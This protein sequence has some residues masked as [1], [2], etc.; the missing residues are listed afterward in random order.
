MSPSPLPPFPLPHL[1]LFRPQ[2]LKPPTT[3][4]SSSS[5]IDSS[6]ELPNR[7]IVSEGPLEMWRVFMEDPVVLDNDPGGGG[8]ALARAH[9]QRNLDRSN[10]IFRPLS[11]YV[12]RVMHSQNAKL[13]MAKDTARLMDIHFGAAAALLGVASGSVTV[14][15]SNAFN[16]RLDELGK[17][18]LR[19]VFRGTAAGSPPSEPVYPTKASHH[20]EN[21]LTQARV[22]FG[23]NVFAVSLEK[24][25]TQNDKARATIYDTVIMTAVMVPASDS[26]SSS[27]SSSSAP[28]LPGFSWPVPAYVKPDVKA[29]HAW[30][31][32]VVDMLYGGKTR[33][34]SATSEGTDAYA[35]YCKLVSAPGFT[36][37]EENA[38]P[39]RG[40]IIYGGHG[41]TPA[42]GEIPFFT[43][44]DWQQVK[45]RLV[46]AGKVVT[47][48]NDTPSGW[49]NCVERISTSTKGWSTYK[50][51]NDKKVYETGC[52]AFYTYKV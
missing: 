4:S 40:C 20:L 52:L 21:I 1:N 9:A 3:S 2:V 43:T 41:M 6:F 34:N 11:S 33:S 37:S 19:L 28:L 31:V 8:A 45:M 42:G 5:S 22:S 18:G 48:A 49:K 51:W 46:A 15:L 27:S 38:V 36:T 24:I 13:A 32:K 17:L 35:Y 16:K 12:Q 29:A 10:S 39:R 23:S 44:T 50:K 47:K 25:A 30:P 7:A 14:D 26:S